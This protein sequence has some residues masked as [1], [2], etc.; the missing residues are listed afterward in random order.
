LGEDEQDASHSSPAST[1]IPLRIP[2]C[3]IL[4]YGWGDDEMQDAGAF[5]RP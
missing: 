5:F 2:V 3:M 1:D 4:L